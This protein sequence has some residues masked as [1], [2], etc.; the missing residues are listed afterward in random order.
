MLILG[1]T[2]AGKSALLVY[3]LQQMAAVYRPRMFII[4]AGGSFSLLGRHFREHGLSVHEVS[5]HPDR[6]V[7]L[8]PFADALQGLDRERRAGAGGE[9]GPW[10]D[11]EADASDESAGRDILGEM[12]IAARVMITGGDAAEDA[13]MS[14]AD[15]L[16]IRNAILKAAESV[17]SSG[18]DQ[19]ITRDVVDALHAIGR[20]RELP[21]TRRTR[22]GRD[23]RRHGAVLLGPGRALLQPPG[24]TLAWGRCHDPGN[25]HPGE[26]RVRG[27]S[28]PWPT[29][30]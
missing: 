8:P 3:L 16:L 17:R 29:F 13:R 2:G 22:A 23:G 12:E 26:G 10:P 18:R 1:P 21:E 20:D 25:G 4:E 5:L 27:P 6:D 19:V 24:P 11:D 14:R 9:H 15:R 28:S 30:P 7:S